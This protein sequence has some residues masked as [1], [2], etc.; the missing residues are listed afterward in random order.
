MAAEPKYELSVKTGEYNGKATWKKVGVLMEGE[1]GP[2]ILLDKTF[3]PAGVPSENERSSILIGCY[4]PKPKD[5]TD[6][7]FPE[8]PKF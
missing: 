8:P 1:K 3:N 5:A 6:F 2:F 7:P 4:E